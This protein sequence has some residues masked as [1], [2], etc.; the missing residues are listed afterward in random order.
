MK[1]TKQQLRRIIREAILLEA[2]SS[3]T[4]D[5]AYVGPYVVDGTEAK[6]GSS[7]EDEEM[8]DQLGSELISLQKQLQAPGADVQGLQRQISLT[9]KTQAQT[10][11][12]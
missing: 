2:D 11:G 5:Q 3:S 9:T 7:D 6:P 4:G 12:K 8:C 1:L 10:C